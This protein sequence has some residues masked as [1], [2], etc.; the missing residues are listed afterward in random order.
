MSIKEN[1]NK[2][3]EGFTSQKSY[4]ESFPLCIPSTVFW[5]PLFTF[6]Y[7]VKIYMLFLQMRFLFRKETFEWQELIMFNLY[8]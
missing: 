8:L 5:I 4:N 6:K 1:K 7:N 2:K 3:A